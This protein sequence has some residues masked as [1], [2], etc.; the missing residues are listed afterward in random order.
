MRPSPRPHSTTQ[1]NEGNTKTCS[2]PREHHRPHLFSV[3]ASLPLGTAV[4]LTL[5]SASPGAVAARTGLETTVTELGGA[6]AELASLRTELEELRADASVKIDLYLEERERLDTA[7]ETREAAT[8]N[9]ETALTRRDQTR[10]AVARQA[11][12]AYK[13]QD[14]GMVNAFTGTEGPAETLERGAH[15]VLLGERRAADLDRAEAARIASDTLADVLENAE[16]EQLSATEDAETARKE[17]ES[18]VVAQEERAEE[19]MADRTRL[20]ARLPEVGEE[21]EGHGSC[22]ES[23]PSGVENGRIPDSALCPLPQSGEMLRADAADAFLELDDAFH[24]EF[25]RPLCVADSYRP[26]H[27][28]VRL[29]QEMLPGMAAEPGTSKHG[30]GVAVDL[31][32]GIDELDSPEHRWMLA[33]A[34]EYGWINPDWAGDGFEPWHWEYD[35]R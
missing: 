25:G 8:D 20:E 9:A 18:A 2:F 22:S 26:Y 13:G 12:A 19:L 21:E 35:P 6:R 14:L 27:E 30:L 10:P 33:A 31:C 17:A 32:G 24:D 11:A 7:V 5:V 16:Q 1:G 28:Q 34:P 3:T 4:L 23:T 29:F 15:L